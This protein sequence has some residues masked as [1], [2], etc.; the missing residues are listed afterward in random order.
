MNFNKDVPYEIKKETFEKNKMFG[1]HQRE[2][3]ANV[4]VL[5]NKIKKIDTEEGRK[6]LQR[7]EEYINNDQKIEELEEINLEY[8]II[9]REDLVNRLY[10]PKEYIN[11]IEDFRDLRPQLIHF[12][13]RDPSRFKE[14]E[15][16]KIK[17]IATSK[18]EYQKLVAGLEA[19]LNPTIVNHVADLDVVYSG[20]FGLGYYQSDTQNQISASVYSA[21]FFA[22]DNVGNFLG[23]GFNADSITPESILMSSKKYM[24]TNAGVYNIDN[25]NDPNDYNSPYSELVENDGYSEVVLARRGEDFDSKAAYVF[26]AI[27]S[28]NIEGHPLYQRAKEYA[29]Q[30]S[31]KLVVYDLVKIRSSYKSFIKSSESLEKNQ[32]TIKISI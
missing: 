21:S 30:N 25:S 26:V 31:L 23:I 8:E 15:L 1:S 11:L 12:F 32:E 4:N 17:K 2:L 20:S 3:L 6:L 13:A 5:K 28:E 29:T 24:T 16:E 19:N 14:K 7:I 10:K 9:Y 27:N 18:E 22:K